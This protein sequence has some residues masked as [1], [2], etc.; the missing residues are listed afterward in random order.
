MIERFLRY[1]VCIPNETLKEKLL[2]LLR[3]RHTSTDVVVRDMILRR[4]SCMKELPRD[5]VLFSQ[6]LGDILENSLSALPDVALTANVPGHCD[7]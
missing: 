2:S 4:I 5:R 1:S 6:A 7:A 3:I